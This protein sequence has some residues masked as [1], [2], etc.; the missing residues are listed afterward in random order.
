MDI[1]VTRK[2]A[3]QPRHS[4]HHGVRAN[5]FRMI[6]PCQVEAQRQ[7]S[8]VGRSLRFVGRIAS[9][10][11]MYGSGILL[12]LPLVFGATVPS[13][14]ITLVDRTIAT[15]DRE[16]RLIMP[17]P[18]LTINTPRTR[19]AF[20]AEA[21]PSARLSLGS[22]REEYFRLN[23]PYG[24]LIY[25]EAVRQQL[26]P[27]LVAA[28]VKA[29]SNFRPRLISHKQARG[30]MQVMPSTGALMGATNLMD[31]DENVRAGARYLKYLHRRFGGDLRLVLAA[32]NAG[33]GN[34]ARFGGI[35]PFRETE[36]YLRKVAVAN[37]H[38]QRQVQK[39]LAARVL[40]ENVRRASAQ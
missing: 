29:E 11:R 27:E 4:T 24:D 32:Y 37:R 13:R 9:P 35:P 14:S 3:I 30:L 18:Q 20:A 31:P 21:A 15:V 19:E 40:E 1:W 22:L 25:R 7:R 28:V 38:Y 26:P 17:E 5:D 39:R 34:I 2:S 8:V 33:E 23:V 16:F 10:I 12:A 36:E 6:C